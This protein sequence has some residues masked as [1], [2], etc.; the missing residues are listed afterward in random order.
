MRK[1][2]AIATFILLLAVFP[3]ITFAQGLPGLEIL[4]RNAVIPGGPTGTFTIHDGL[5]TGTNGIYIKYGET[6]LMAD[7]AVLNRKTGDVVADG[8]VRI[9]TGAQV[10]VGEHITYNMNT[11]LMQSEQFRAGMPPIFAEGKTLTG[12]TTNKTYNVRH[13]YITTDDIFD[14]EFRIQASRMKIVPGKYV[15][16]WNAVVYAEDVPVFYFPYYRRNLGPH[17][18]NLNFSAG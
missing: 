6:V 14:P 10:W 16:L 4:A 15:E 9:Q 12:D 2:P 7:T 5:Y 3:L 18:N 13:G 1:I 17:A 11:H 8:Q